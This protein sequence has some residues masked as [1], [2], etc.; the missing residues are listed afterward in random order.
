MGVHYDHTREKHTVRWTQD[1]RRRI[2]C[3]DTER[4]AIAFDE[5]VRIGAARP[6]LRETERAIP[7]PKRGDGI[8]SYETAKGR[9]WRFTFRESDGTLSSR[10]GFTSRAAAATSK[11]RLLEEIRRG[12]LTVSL[13]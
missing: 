6:E 12:E 4:E 5:T 11:R 7:E 3:F 9:C 13:T 1:G 2:K 10:R 8:Y